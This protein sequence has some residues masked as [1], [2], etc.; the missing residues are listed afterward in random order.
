MGAW[1][2]CRF[3][4]IGG[5]GGGVDKKE[6]V[7]LLRGRVVVD[8]PMHIMLPTLDPENFPIMLL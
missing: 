5:R 6:G 7:M 4:E 1:T 2:V 3:K 8:I